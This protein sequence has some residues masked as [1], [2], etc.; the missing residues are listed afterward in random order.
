MSM[1]HAPPSPTWV[2]HLR[3]TQARPQPRVPRHRSTASARLVGVLAWGLT[4]LAPAIAQEGAGLQALRAPAALPGALSA[5]E[6]RLN[7]GIGDLR[8]ELQAA[9]IGH[10]QPRGRVFGDYYL[11]GPG[12]GEG[13]VSGGLRITSGV[14]FGGY[15]APLPSARA[16]GL[17]GPSGGALG[18]GRAW[19]APAFGPRL[20]EREGHRQALPYIGLGYTSLSTRHG[21][22]LNA[23]IGLGG[24]RTG[25]RVRFGSG[26]P[27]AQQVENILNDLRLAPVLQLGVSY[28]F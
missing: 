3:R 7:L 23:D 2:G 15:A 22:S 25:E 28:A 16:A 13:E 27:N 19:G 21:W 1:P 24:L 11:T 17:L 12:F 10:A 26:H 9:H 18:S 5:G 20:P 4:A 8:L 14:A 6:Q